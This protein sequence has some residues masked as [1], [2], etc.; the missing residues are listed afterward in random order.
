MSN[1]IP[2]EVE[3]DSVVGLLHSMKS[4]RLPFN[5]IKSDSYLL[6][7][8]YLLNNKEILGD[9]GQSHQQKRVLLE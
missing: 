1:Y 4:M 5:N 3:L 8:N 9:K 2:L 7:D 6:D